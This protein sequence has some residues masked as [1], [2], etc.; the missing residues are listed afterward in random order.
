M[1]VNRK[2]LFG[3][4]LEVLNENESDDD[5]QRLMDIAS[6]DGSG[7]QALE[8]YEY[9]DL[10]EHQIRSIY[11]VVLHNTLQNDVEDLPK[12]L[13]LRPPEYTD[14]ETAVH[15][16]MAYKA[17]VTKAEQPERLLKAMNFD[18]HN[19]FTKVYGITPPRNMEFD[20]RSGADASGGLYHEDGVYLELPTLGGLIMFTFSMEGSHED[21]PTDPL[22]YLKNKKGDEVWMDIDLSGNLRYDTDQGETGL[23]KEEIPD[24][25]RKHMGYA[26]TEPVEGW[27][28]LPL[29]SAA[30]IRERVDRNYLFRMINEVIRENEDEDD[31]GIEKK[32]NDFIAK[33][34]S[35][36]K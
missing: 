29:G 35:L 4:I 3:T 6:S 30:P 14:Q 23:S 20:F 11:N 28:E 19:E 18:F 10:T 8:M 21:V 1:K 2:Y 32:I 5:F 13:E 16:D 17:I 27:K 9:F 7:I 34:T 31:M 22:I 12:V 24:L 25:I 33:K 36:L 26:T 15:R